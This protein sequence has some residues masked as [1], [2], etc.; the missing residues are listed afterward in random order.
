MITLQWFL[1]TILN[2]FCV[3]LLL[4]AY[5]NKENPGAGQVTYIATCHAAALA[6]LCTGLLAGAYLRSLWC[7]S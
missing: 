4:G 3:G 2:S 7:K 6:G 5:I 1:L